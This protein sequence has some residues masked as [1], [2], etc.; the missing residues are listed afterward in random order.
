MITDFVHS[1]K[2][3][4]AVQVIYLIAVVFLPPQLPHICKLS[5]SETALW[6]KLRCDKLHHE[7]FNCSDIKQNSQHNVM[8]FHHR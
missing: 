8:V 2:L 7:R 1:R 6:L 3:E 5:D 4:K